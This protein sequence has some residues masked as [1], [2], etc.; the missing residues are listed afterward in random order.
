MKAGKLSIG[1]VLLA[2]GIFAIYWSQDHSPNAGFGE[3]IVSE[4]AG[5]YVLDKT[6]Y[7]AL[8]VAGSIMAILGSIRIFKS[9]S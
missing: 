3:K 1:I 6:T 4:I 5:K 2:V 9:L 7:Y 8:M